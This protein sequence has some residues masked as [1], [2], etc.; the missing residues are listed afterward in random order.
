MRGLRF[1]VAGLFTGATSAFAAQQ[2]MH[3]HPGMNAAVKTGGGTMIAQKTCPV[4][5]KPVRQDVFVEQEGVK[6][7]FCCPACIP[8]FKDSPMKYLPAVY[9]QDY[10]Q[11]VQVKCP[12]MGGPLD[13]KTFIEYQGRKIG[14]CCDGCPQKFKADPAKYLSKSKE[15]STEQ[16]HCPV[17]GKAINPKFSTEYEGKT[18]YFSS[19]AALTQFKAEPAR[20]AAGL[21]LESGIVA[22]GPIADEDL[23]LYI[24]ASGE[25]SIHKRKDLKLV[26]YQGKTYFLLGD[27]GVTR[28][29]ADPAEY[30]KALDVQMKT[31]PTAQQTLTPDAG[32]GPMSHQGREQGTQMIDHAGHQ[33]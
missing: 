4:T 7:Y 15:W 12:V 8:Q 24:T 31:P 3:E 21:R 30:V 29:K 14:F 20:C 16:V 6:V 13:G 28:F 22:R 5:G 26:A 2:G 19:E 27:D 33:H 10:P 23:I 1:I 32:S 17:T 11:S 25:S 18:V 9:K